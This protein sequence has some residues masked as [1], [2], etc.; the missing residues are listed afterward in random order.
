MFHINNSKHFNWLR[1]DNSAATHID[2][3]AWHLFP[4][5]LKRSSFVHISG[6]ET[7]LA[8]SQGK[9]PMPRLH[10]EK[11]CLLYV[12]LPA[13]SSVVNTA[14]V[15][16]GNVGHLFVVLLGIR[17]QVEVDDCRVDGAGLSVSL[18]HQLAKVVFD[19]LHWPNR[20][21]SDLN[22]S[23]VSWTQQLAWEK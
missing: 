6:T 20:T 13:S 4:L 23:P 3:Q 22:L 16:Y 15:V 10:T 12:M 21:T 2:Q 18:L 7:W 9:A 14:C 11:C 8:L 5:Q 17:P 19:Q 1:M